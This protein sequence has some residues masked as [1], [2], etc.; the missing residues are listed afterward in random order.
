MTERL[1]KLL[2]RA[3]LMKRS[4]TYHRFWKRHVAICRFSHWEIWLSEEHQTSKKKQIVGN[5]ELGN[6]NSYYEYI[7]FYHYRVCAK[8]RTTKAGG[9]CLFLYI[10][11]RSMALV[12]FTCSHGY[13]FALFVFSL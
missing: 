7:S 4:I 12:C 13:I 9:S 2:L 10:L 8:I 1:V 6:K 5:L 11:H 3:N